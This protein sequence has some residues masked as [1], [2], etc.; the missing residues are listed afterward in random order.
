MGN[1]I[2]CK[3]GIELEEEF[4]TA[5]SEWFR[6]RGDSGFVRCSGTILDK[7]AGTDAIIWGVPTDFTYYFSGKDYTEVLPGTVDLSIGPK[8]FFG[9]R[10]GN[11]HKGYT[12]FERPVLIL[13]LEVDSKFIRNWMNNLVDSFK[14]KLPEILEIGQALYWDWCDANSVAF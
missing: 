2:S 11:S 12:K 3:L 9:V 5:C 14:A 4:T 7:E 13:G 8:V 10:T 6:A 1:Y